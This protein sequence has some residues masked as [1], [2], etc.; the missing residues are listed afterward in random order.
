MKRFFS[1]VGAL[2]FPPRCAACKA[3][4]S[5]L[6]KGEELPAF[7]PAC[8]K[9]WQMA[10]HAQC[11]Q[12]Y[13]AYFA[14]T[15]RRK[16][17]ERAGALGLVKLAAYNGAHARV[18]RATV[19]YL[20]NHPV[21]RVFD[22][23]AAELEQ[24]LL[25]A[26]KKYGID[27]DGAVLCHLPRSPKSARRA[28]MDQSKEL[29]MALSRRIGIPCEAI[30]FKNRNTRA[31][32]TLS[33]TERRKNLTGS[34]EVHGDCKGRCVVLVDDVVTTG[35][36]MSVA[37]ELLRRNGAKQVLCV[38]IATTEKSRVSHHENSW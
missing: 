15:C 30:L 7:C 4:L 5:P 3:R 6:S 25:A 22:A 27:K 32:K 16:P 33:A 21:A 17:M 12:C 2:F 1:T 10:I 26:M 19:L 29:A 11:S 35:A 37:T 23:L 34:F 18:V 13:Q 38:S 24:G 8:A 20:K 9:E 28:G 36:S 14:C 31:Q